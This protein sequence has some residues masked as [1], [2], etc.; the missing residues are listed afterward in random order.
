MVIAGNDECEL[1]AGHV[2]VLEIGY[3]DTISAISIELCAIWIDI[4]AWGG[5]NTT[6]AICSIKTNQSASGF[7]GKHVTISWRDSDRDCSITRYEMICFYTEDISYTYL[8]S[9][10]GWSR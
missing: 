1:R 9:V 8:A 4:D 10:G 3:A 7:I 6:V 2:R 5:S